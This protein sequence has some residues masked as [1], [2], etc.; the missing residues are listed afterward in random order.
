MEDHEAQVDAN[1]VYSVGLTS[2][3]AQILL[4]QYGRNELPEKHKPKV[5]CTIPM[6]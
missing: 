6:E 5:N 3:E 1:L 4:E 2:A